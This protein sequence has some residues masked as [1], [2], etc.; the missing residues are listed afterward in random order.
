MSYAIK[1]SVMGLGVAAGVS[2]IN[3]QG[4]TADKDPSFVTLSYS[5]AGLNLGYAFMTQ[6]IQLQT[7]K[8]LKWV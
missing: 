7:K 6:I 1:G 8:R 4:S 5:I 2:T 3:N